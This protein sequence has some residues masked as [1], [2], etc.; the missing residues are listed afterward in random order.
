VAA[1]AL[2]RDRLV[3]ADHRIVVAGHA[4]V[5]DVGGAAGK[6]LRI[7][8]RHV[9][10]GSGGQRG[11]AVGEV[12]ERHLLAGRL[13][14]QVDHDRLHVAAEPMPRELGLERA[15]GIVVSAHEQAAHDLDHQELAPALQRELNAAAAGRAGRQVERADQAVIALAV[16]DHL[17]LVEDMVAGGDQIG[18]GGVEV[19]AEAGGDAEPAG[20]ILAVDHDRIELQGRAQLGQLLQ[21]DLAAGAPDDVAAEQDPHADPAGA[22]TEP[23]GGDQRWL[24]RSVT[25]ASRS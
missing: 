3:H 24:A 10:M 21:Q 8:R 14:V 9:G 12:R 11:A 4:D 5:G 23:G 25:T 6:D 16:A 19:L 7:G 13:G 18:A 22:V 20:G 1:E 17:A 15:E 2:Q